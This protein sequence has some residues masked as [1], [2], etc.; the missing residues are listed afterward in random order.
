MSERDSFL[1]RMGRAV[2]RGEL[3]NRVVNESQNRAR[4][5]EFDAIDRKRKSEEDKYETINSLV[6]PILEE[7]GIATWG[8]DNF[9]LNY[10]R[11]H[12]GG[13][14]RWGKRVTFSWSLSGGTG[15]D[16]TSYNLF[17]REGGLFPADF[18]LHYRHGVLSAGI[19]K[20]REVFIIAAEDGGPGPVDQGSR[21]PPGHG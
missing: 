16:F 12:F 14:R 2:K 13:R 8:E 6:A 3:R 5:A 15:V 11:S 10:E 9:H 20:L 21:E 1:E 18:E 17:L 7:V 4:A 19:S